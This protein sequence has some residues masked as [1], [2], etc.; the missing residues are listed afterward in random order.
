M[1]VGGLGVDVGID[2]D[3]YAAD[4]AGHGH[5]AR[6]VDHHEV[7]DVDV[8]QLLPRRDRAAGAAAAQGV[9]GDRRGQCPVDL[10]RVGVRAPGDVDQ[11]V[12]GHAH[13]RHVGAVRREV[14]QHLDVGARGGVE[15]ALGA[16]ELL[17]LLGVP[18]VGADQQDVQR[19]L[20]GRVG[21]RFGR[22]VLGVAEVE[23]VLPDVAV[24][25]LVVEISGPRRAEYHHRQNDRRP[26][27]NAPSAA[28]AVSVRALPAPPV[29][30]RVVS[31]VPVVSAVLGR[32]VLVL[33]CEGHRV[34]DRGNLFA[35]TA[36]RQL[37]ASHPC[38]R[39]RICR[40]SGQTHDAPRGLPA[41]APPS[42]ATDPR[43]PPA[44]EPLGHPSPRT[45]RARGR[46]ALGSPAPRT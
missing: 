15:G 12:P 4:G 46:A 40:A 16:A 24:E 10:A 14:Q 29:A 23:V 1:A 35:H 13:D 7:I 37:P 19:L 30:V 5:H 25:V 28:P 2:A 44:V 41:G 39:R 3:R 8:G 38:A 20:P 43:P 26:A 17:V 34:L 31:A 33:R 27:Q 45:G 36:S 18:C 11:G 22:P 21:L 42:S 32:R 9:V 6:E